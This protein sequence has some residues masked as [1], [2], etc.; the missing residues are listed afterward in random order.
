[1]TG[2]FY[3]V[4]IED[5]KNYGCR[6]MQEIYLLDLF[7]NIV[8]RIEPTLAREIWFR[9]SDFYDSKTYGVEEYRL[10]VV[11]RNVEEKDHWRGAFFYEGKKLEVT[12][13]LEKVNQ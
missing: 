3:K 13:T 9:L 4:I 11:R 6:E 8:K 5:F 7:S 2:K 1:M 10:L 12:A